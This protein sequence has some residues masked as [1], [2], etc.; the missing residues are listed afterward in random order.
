MNVYLLKNMK[1]FQWLVAILLDDFPNFYI[2][3]MNSGISTTEKL[4]LRK[5]IPQKLYFISRKY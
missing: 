5:I 2:G 3:K 4:T 1:C